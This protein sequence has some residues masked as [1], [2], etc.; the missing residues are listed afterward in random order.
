[1]R[2]NE[3]HKLVPPE[4]IKVAVTGDVDAINQI[5][6]HY[7]PYIIKLATQKLYDEAGNAHFYVNEDLKRHLE[8]KLITAILKFEI[9]N[10]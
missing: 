5:V 10:Q 7:Q 4:I 6:T 2:K 9:R 1:M 8:T 3:S